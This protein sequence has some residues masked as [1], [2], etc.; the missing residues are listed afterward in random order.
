MQRVRTVDIPPQCGLRSHL[1]DANFSDAFAVDLTHSDHSALD[2]YQLTVARTPYWV[3]RAVDIRNCAVSFFDLKTAGIAPADP[4]RPAAAYQ[5]GDSVGV[6]LIEA[7]SDSEVL[8]VASDKHLDSRCSILKRSVDGRYEMVWSSA[9]HVHNPLGHAYMV[10][11]WP[12]HK[13]VVRAM[14]ADCGL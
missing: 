12:G 1:A 6:F 14:L 7:I 5:V 9:V 11:V 8:L 10:L 13:L 2:I 4:S 3:R